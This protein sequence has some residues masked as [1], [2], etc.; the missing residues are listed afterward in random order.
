MWRIRSR[1]RARLD[2]VLARRN[3]ELVELQ[4]NGRGDL[5]AVQSL[6]ELAMCA[7]TRDVYRAQQ[8]TAVNF[9]NAIPTTTAQVTLWNGE[10]DDGRSYLLIGVQVTVGLSSFGGPFAMSCQACLNVGKKTNPAGTLLTIRGTGGQ[11]YKGS[12]RVSLART[13]TNDGWFPLGHERKGF[14]GVD[15]DD[16]SW[17]PMTFRAQSMIVI[18]PGHMLSIA[19]MATASGGLA[20]HRSGF[21]WKEAYLPTNAR[22]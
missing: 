7:A 3:N 17:T 22:G 1:I 10:P 18:P 2:E 11:S 9:V 15:P 13:I 20:T 8:T 14:N 5:L 4:G 19:M 21:I 12:G 16:F 6:P